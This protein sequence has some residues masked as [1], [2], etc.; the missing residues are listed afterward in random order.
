MGGRSQSVAA[1][2]DRDSGGIRAMREGAFMLSGDFT[3][4][5]AKAILDRVYI[6]MKNKTPAEIGYEVRK[7]CRVR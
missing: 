4:K 6:Q 2:E 1:A 5:E 3:E 7:S